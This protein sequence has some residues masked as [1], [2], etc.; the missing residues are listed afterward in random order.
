MV[1]AIRGFT[2]VSHFTA[3]ASGME[4]LAVAE[5]PVAI[6]IQ[7]PDEIR[8]T[9]KESVIDQIVESLTGFKAVPDSQDGDDQ[10]N[11]KEHVFF[12]G[13]GNIPY[14]YSA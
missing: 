12:L 13:L 1:I 5:Y 2:D 10:W 7:E 11:P 6:G 3:K 9:I 14:R 4:D 8:D